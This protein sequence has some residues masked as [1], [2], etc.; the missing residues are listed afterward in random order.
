MFITPRGAF[1]YGV[2]ENLESKWYFKIRIKILSEK[3]ATFEK[4]LALPTWIICG[5]PCYAQ[6]V[7]YVERTGNILF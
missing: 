7:V 4:Q 6:A 2:V 1:Y 5:Q 3:M